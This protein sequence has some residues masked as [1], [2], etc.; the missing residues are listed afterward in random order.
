[1]QN[2]EKREVI[3]QGSHISKSYPMCE[4]EF[5][6]MIELLRPR[7]NMANEFLAL[8]DVSFEFYKGEIIGFVGLN[9]S[10]KSTLSRIIAGISYPTQGEVEVRGECSM[11]SPS[12]GMNI[13][14]TGRENIF[15]K[16]LLLGFSEKQIRDMEA[17]IVDFA[18]IGSH[19]EQPMRTY[20]SGMRARLGFAISVMLDP[21]VLI[22]DEALAVGDPTF[23]T[24]CLDKMREFKA[25]GK[26]IVFVSHAA[27]QMKGF[28]DRVMWL[29]HGR[30][31]GILPTEQILPAY[32]GFTKE[33]NKMSKEQRQTFEPSLEEYRAKY[34]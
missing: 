10:G 30:K 22:V 9:G 3:I 2:A 5:Q 15:Y 34:C 20:S 16:C 6:R 29:H 19:I 1:M 18:E 27:G 21:D 14:L 23:A 12:S 17:Q 11:L 24:K 8:K 33:F 26:T 25:N 31:L 32:E 13:Q 7:A 4:S 28:C